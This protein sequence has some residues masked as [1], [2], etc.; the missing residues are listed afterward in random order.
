M[1]FVVFSF[2]ITK[3]NCCV[4]PAT[5]RFFT[6]RDLRL[7]PMHF[8]IPKQCHLSYSHWV[9]RHL[10]FHLRNMKKNP[11]KKFQHPSQRHGFQWRV[12]FPKAHRHRYIVCRGCWLC[13]CGE[14]GSL[15]GFCQHSNRKRDLA[16]KGFSWPSLRWSAYW[17]LFRMKIYVFVEV[18][19]VLGGKTPSRSLVEIAC[20]FNDL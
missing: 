5:F 8:K 9:G 16:W 14:F 4:F 13:R 12:A 19:Q 6:P 18:H 2:R 17:R 3:G 15:S 11:N 10:T 20:Q 1:F 7:Q